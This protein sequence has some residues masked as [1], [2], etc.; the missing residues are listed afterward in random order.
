MTDL[1]SWR[2]MLRRLG[3][4]ERKAVEIESLESRPRYGEILTLLIEGKQVTPHA[5]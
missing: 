4:T 3:E 5:S 2:V 1:T